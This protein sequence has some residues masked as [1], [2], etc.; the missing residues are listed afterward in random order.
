MTVSGKNQVTGGDTERDRYDL[1]DLELALI[2]NNQR[3]SCATSQVK[4]PTYCRLCFQVSHVRFKNI[5]RQQLLEFWVILQQIPT[6]K[7][8]YSISVQ[9]LGEL[10]FYSHT[11]TT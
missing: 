4:T 11:Q 7:A 8:H 10:K 5:E 3:I 1:Q 9:A 6:P 2:E